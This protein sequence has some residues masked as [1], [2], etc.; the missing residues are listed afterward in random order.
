[1][2]KEILWWYSVPG[3]KDPIYRELAISKDIDLSGLDGFTTFKE[4]VDFK[5]KI[6]S[7]EYKE[8][9][10]YNSIVNRFST[11]LENYIDKVKVSEFNIKRLQES[12]YRVETNLLDPS[13][14]RIFNL[15]EEI[16]YYN[17]VREIYASKDDSLVGISMSDTT[18]DRIKELGYEVELMNDSSILYK[19]F[20]T[21]KLKKIPPMFRDTYGPCYNEKLSEHND[22][23]E[24]SGTETKSL[25]ER[26]I[27]VVDRLITSGKTPRE[28]YNYVRNSVLYN[29]LA[30]GDFSMLSEDSQEFYNKVSNNGLN[31]NTSIEKMEDRDRGMRVDSLESIFFDMEKCKNHKDA[32]WTKHQDKLLKELALKVDYLMSRTGETV[33]A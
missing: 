21:A 28:I 15:P 5:K 11:Y 26:H 4:C 32:N 8:E 33:K 3:E 23:V 27:D 10:E 17:I 1:M 14:C 24:L 16:E 12:G 29:N 6:A 30:P 31:H 9:Q 19:I 20:N 22:N 18:R 25:K 2:S 13:L 7:D